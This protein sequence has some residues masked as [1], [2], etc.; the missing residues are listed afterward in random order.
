MW[1]SLSA[2]LLFVLLSA[3]V[4]AAKITSL[5]QY[6]LV[7]SPQFGGYVS[8]TKSTCAKKDCPNSPSLYYWLITSDQDFTSKPLIIWFN[9][10]PGASN[11]YGPFMET[12]PYKFNQTGNLVSD[13]YSWTR[14]ANYMVIEQ[15]LS[16]GAST[17]KPH[18]KNL[19]PH[20]N[21]QSS[22]QFFNAL[23]HIYTQ[24]PFLKR[25]KVYLMG[26]S[27]AGMYIAFIAKEIL[28]HEKQTDI[29]LGGIMVNDI[30]V[31]PSLQQSYDS[32]YA[33][34]HGM[35]SA[36]QK[37]VVDKIYDRCKQLIQQHTPSTVEANK[38][39]A[40]I[41]STIKNMSGLYLP[42]IMHP[43][44]DY[45]TLSNYLSKANVQTAL[46]MKPHSPY[47]LF[48]NTIGNN[49]RVGEQDSISY[50]YNKLLAQ[51]VQI[52]IMSG[53]LDATDSNFLGI[54]AMIQQLQWPGKKRYMQSKTVQWKD[55]DKAKTVLGYIKSDLKLA[56]VK[57]LDGGHM[58][59]YDQP[60]VAR[61]V[62]EFVSV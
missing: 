31:S 30:W 26:E 55:T 56:R 54:D 46:H 57:V 12:G 32:Q 47:V 7:T 37:K 34:T 16:V 49:F 20:N 51:N 18:N 50:L 62:K 41:M 60:K 44:P 23:Q 42:N 53:L 13:P 17:V 21:T 25:H 10:G 1:R 45:S 29:K 6:G 19:I 48:S 43:A 4:F 22:K 9:G 28:S 15:P 40:K 27:Y 33:Y 11:M 35:I 24:H 3:H 52:V 14:F 5:P 36:N 58:L 2:C 61:L 38:A 8:I 59:P 39:C